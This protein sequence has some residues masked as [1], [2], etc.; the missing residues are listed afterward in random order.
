[1]DTGSIGLALG[2]GML[3]AVNPCGFALLPAYLSLFV[4]DHQ[5][6]PR[7]IAL[8]RAA[9]ATLALTLGFAAVFLVFG[10]AVAPVA[11]SLQS[12]LPGFTVVL[13]LVVAT[14]GLWVAL[15]RR[16]P[17]FT[18][19]AGRRAGGTVTASWVSMA[20]FGASYA[21]ASLGCTIAPF[22]A[23]VVAA[24]RSGSTWS[25]VV[26]FL[27]YAAGMGLVVGVAAVATALARAGVVARVRRLGGVLPRVG[28]AVLMVAGSYVAWY[29][30]WELRVLHAGADSDP[31]VDAA[32][33]VQQWLVSRVEA[34]GA[35]GFAL[36]LGA[37]LIVAA[38][39]SRSRAGLPHD[40][41]PD[42]KAVH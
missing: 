42:G 25:G 41:A 14:A 36:V 40:D 1:M 9:R 28:G 21:L 23:V 33:S 5:V 3:A 18:L 16:L 20:G 22:L 12:Y 27:A 4:L 15:G 29:G 6:L 7:R 39:G 13:G 24:F 8:V 30:F 37:I 10:L 2:A 34:V 17:T 38:R 31:L 19:R 32:A 11:A 26:L 35:V